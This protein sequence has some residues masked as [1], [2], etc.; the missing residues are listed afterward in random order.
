M[1]WLRFAFQAGVIIISGIYIT[2]SADVIAAK[3]KLGDMVVGV[4]LLAL[5][6]SLPE[7]VTGSTAAAINAPDLAL[8][9]I[10]GSN[11][12]NL[13][14]LGLLDIIEGPGPMLLKINISNILP[15]LFALLIGSI[16]G[17]V[18]VIYSITELSPWQFRLSLESIVILGVY[19]VGL[20]LMYKFGNRG[21]N[22]DELEW[23][24]GEGA[25]VR[26]V[27]LPGYSLY[28][29][30][31]V[32]IISA[33]VI[34][35][36]GVRITTTADEI[37]IIT[38]LGHTFMGPVLLAAATSLPELVTTLAALKIG[39]Y[40]L[41]AGNVLGSNIFNLIIL[42]WIDFFYSGSILAG[43][44]LVNLIPLLAFM[45]MT[46]LM[47]IGLFYRSKRS[48]LRLGWGAAALLVIYFLTIWLLWQ[49]GIGIII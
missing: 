48:F 38:G 39:A 6:T 49:L 15:G 25:E 41:A 23:M 12:F 35:F 2:R 32:F 16:I 43:A 22:W 36:T 18:I 20:R 8:G 37:A 31:F 9:N 29:A 5:A 14:I 24:T 19:L 42:V 26:N 17:I 1:I 3:S 21:E 45:I 10:L 30:Y 44:S 11:V 4:F 13:A 27:P 7:L 33:I 28:Q 40:N 46:L 47:L 34:V